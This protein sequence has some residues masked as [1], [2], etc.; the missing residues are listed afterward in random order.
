MDRARVVLLYDGLR[1]VRYA[2]PA[3]GEGSTGLAVARVDGAGEAEASALTLDRTA[4]G[5]RY[6]TAPWVRDTSVRDLLKPDAEASALHRAPDG[7]TDPVPAMARTG[8]C[9]S[10]PTLQVRDWGATRLMADLGEPAPAHLTSGRPTAPGEVTSRTALT[11]WGR[12]GCS[13]AA[14]RAHGVRS[15]NSWRYAEERLPET[16]GTAS[17][18]CAR[19]DT[20]RGTGSTVLVAFRVPDRTT[21][22][23]V[24]RAENSPACGRR[25]PQVLAGVLWKSAANHWYLLATGSENVTSITA[26]GAV[27]GAAEGHALAVPAKRGARPEL[28]G[29]LTDGSHIR[30]PR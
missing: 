16:D 4:D 1:V 17:W 11:E 6:L 26:T 10:W 8:E 9:L 21:S 2:E 19:A 27:R 12:I 24:A 28:T 20:W 18:L 7:V 3:K 23:L 15:V 14:L 29:R 5:V 25:V 13:L 30:P 22:T